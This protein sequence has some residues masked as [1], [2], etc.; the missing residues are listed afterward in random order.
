M[1]V[2]SHEGSFQS[3]SCFQG[4]VPQA[5]PIV[6]FLATLESVSKH[7]V[8]FFLFFYMLF[9]AFCSS[10]LFCLTHNVK[11]VLYM[12]GMTLNF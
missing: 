9:F 11:P 10:F 12:S 2:I 6:S 7:I 4:T 5:I 8:A 1:K 3:P